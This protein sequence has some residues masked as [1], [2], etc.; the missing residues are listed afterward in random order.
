MKNCESSL[1]TKKFTFKRDNHFLFNQISKILKNPSFPQPRIN[2][3]VKWVLIHCW[4]DTKPVPDISLGY[5]NL[6]QGRICTHI[7]KI[8]KPISQE[9][10]GS[11]TKNSTL[12]KIFCL[13]F[14]L[15]FNFLFAK[16]FQP[17]NTQFISYLSYIF[18]FIFRKYISES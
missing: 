7:L 18:S 15:C 11:R 12:N 14:L 5:L 9:S 3:I 10:M 17:K 13:V 8:L 1:L 2:E 4:L 6:Y 16:T